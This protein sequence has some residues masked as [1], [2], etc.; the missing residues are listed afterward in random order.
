MDKEKGYI[1]RQGT[2]YLST[3]RYQTLGKY[4]A[5]KEVKVVYKEEVTDSDRASEPPGEGYV[6]VG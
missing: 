4:V 3:N 1:E 6:W 5:S 2:K